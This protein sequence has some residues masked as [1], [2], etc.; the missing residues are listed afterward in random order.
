[1]AINETIVTGRKFRYLINE[2]TKLWQRI[3]FWTKACDVE[4]DDGQTAEEKLG[5]INGITDSLASTSSNTALA[6]SAG[7]NLQNQIT[8]ISNTLNN[9]GTQVTMTLDGT[10]LSITII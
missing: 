9:L 3:S 5:A 1:M 7:K 2:A 4:F 8:Q 10:T 6:A